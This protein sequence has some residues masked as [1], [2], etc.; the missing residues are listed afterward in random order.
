MKVR[1]HTCMII[2][3][4]ALV[5]HFNNCMGYNYTSTGSLE[6][7]HAVML[8]YTQKRLHFS[9]DVMRAWTELA[10]IDYNANVGRPQAK[11]QEG[12]DK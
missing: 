3:R 10:V 9:Y 2:C 6:V 12:K 1:S 7:F 4:N 11:T 5:Y 8:K